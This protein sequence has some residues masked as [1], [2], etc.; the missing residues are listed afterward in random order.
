[1]EVYAMDIT[2]ILVDI[3]QHDLKGWIDEGKS[4]SELMQLD[5]VLRASISKTTSSITSGYNKTMSDD[6]DIVVAPVP[7]VTGVG[8]RPDGTVVYFVNQTIN[9]TSGSVNNTQT[10][11][12]TISNSITSNPSLNSGLLSISVI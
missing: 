11:A 9:S 12:I 6:D 1:M 5:P 4:V 10:A 7:E 2:I 8:V 3:N